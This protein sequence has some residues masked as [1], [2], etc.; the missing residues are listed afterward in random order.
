MSNTTMSNQE[1][2]AK[3]VAKMQKLDIIEL[4]NFVFEMNRNL[5]DYA[6]T[7]VSAGLDALEARMSESEFIR[8][9]GQL[10]AAL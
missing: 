7:L 1:I 3:L 9:C 10:E 6:D 2:T 5:A 8:F 4:A